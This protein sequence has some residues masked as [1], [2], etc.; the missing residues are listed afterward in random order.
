MCLLWLPCPHFQYLFRNTI[1]VHLFP[2]S[3]T[4]LLLNITLKLYGANAPHE[5]IVLMFPLCF[6]L[7]VGVSP[8]SKVSCFG[9]E[10]NS[11]LVQISGSCHGCLLKADPALEQHRSD[12]QWACQT[13]GSALSHHHYS[14]CLSYFSVF[15]SQ[16]SHPSEPHR[17]IIISCNSLHVSPWGSTKEFLHL[18]C[19]LHCTRKHLLDRFFWFKDLCWQGT[20]CIPKDV[21][22]EANYFHLKIYPWCL[23]WGHF[24]VF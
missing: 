17:T 19:V 13:P 9:C 7:M 12:T 18:L 3:Q 1:L 5:N 2:V 11:S 20:C 16:K 23:A 22:P 8:F 6:F 4:N 10:E 24:N 15:G 14:C 21:F